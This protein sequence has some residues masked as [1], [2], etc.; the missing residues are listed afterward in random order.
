MEHLSHLH[1]EDV[2]VLNFMDSQGLGLEDL[3]GHLHRLLLTLKSVRTLIITNNLGLARALDASLDQYLPD[4]VMGLYLKESRTTPVLR[5][6]LGETR[7]RSVLL[8][9]WN[10]CPLKQDLVDPLTWALQEKEAGA[11]SGAG[12]YGNVFFVMNRAAL[13]DALRG[14]DDRRH[15]IETMLDLG[16]ESVMVD[17]MVVHGP[18]PTQSIVDCLG[19]LFPRPK[20]QDSSCDS[21]SL[22]R[23]PSLAAPPPSPRPGWTST[24]GA[25]GS[26]P[27]LTP[28]PLRTK[29]PPPGPRPPALSSSGSPTVSGPTCPAPPVDGPMSGS[30]PPSSLKSCLRRRRTAAGSPAQHQLS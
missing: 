7:V 12:P 3:L 24:P 4:Q 17:G 14:G 15:V 19:Y 8:L 10:F 13:A 5:S 21:G 20:D 22:Y 27:S 9:P 16:L 2:T 25:G 1:G 23:A 11:I 6:L 30:G 28:S 18:C 26:G 29:G